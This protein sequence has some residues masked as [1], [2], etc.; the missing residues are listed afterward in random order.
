MKEFEKVNLVHGMVYFE[1][2]LQHALQLLSIAGT[3]TNTTSSPKRSRCAHHRVR[4]RQAGP[5][6][7]VRELHFSEFETSLVR[8]VSNIAVKYIRRLEN[9]GDN[10]SPQAMC[11]C[12]QCV[13]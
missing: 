9:K 5:L 1:N 12:A 6:N 3:L 11:T 4:G 7:H 10:K 2:E 13:G 8:Y